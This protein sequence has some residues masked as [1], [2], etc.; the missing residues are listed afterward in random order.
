MGLL[1][2]GEEAKLLLTASELRTDGDSKRFLLYVNKLIL[3]KVGEQ[4]ERSRLVDI[5]KV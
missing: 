3:Q 1:T 4:S 2:A 5:K